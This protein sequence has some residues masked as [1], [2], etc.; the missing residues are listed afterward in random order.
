MTKQRNVAL[1]LLGAGI[2]IASIASLSSCNIVRAGTRCVA[3][4]PAARDST[5]VLFCRGGRWTKTLTF[6]EAARVIFAKTPTKVE[7]VS[8]ADVSTAAGT[9]FPAV[10]VRVLNPFGDGIEGAVVNLSTAD[11]VGG[12]GIAGGLATPATTGPGGTLTFTPAANTSAGTLKLLASASNANGP[13]EPA[14][15]SLTVTAGPVTNV[16]VV[17][18]AGQSTVELTNFAQPVVI[19][20]SDAFGNGVSGLELAT[21]SLNGCVTQAIGTP[22]STTGAAGT[23]SITLTGNLPFGMTT[24]SDTVATGRAAGS[25]PGTPGSPGS[26]SVTYSMNV[27]SIPLAP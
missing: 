24:C 13:T 7:L 12:A 21:F 6:G 9:Y 26:P 23:A 5:H 4:S 17:S 2:A 10:T 14:V 15:V 27:T 8:K 25:S 1:R 3:N 18:G 16:A 19:K 11:S 22:T 20:A